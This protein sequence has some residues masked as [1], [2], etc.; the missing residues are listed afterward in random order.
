MANGTNQ[1][2][3]QHGLNLTMKLVLGFSMIWMVRYIDYPGDATAI[4]TQKYNR[5]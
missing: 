2:D 3:E 5:L 1:Y 4:Y